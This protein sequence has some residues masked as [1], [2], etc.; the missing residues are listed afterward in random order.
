MLPPA[1]AADPEGLALGFD[2]PRTGSEQR[3]D[4][5]L[6]EA[7]ASPRHAHAHAIARRRERDEHDASVRRAAHAVTARR[8]GVD[9]QLEELPHGSGIPAE[10]TIQGRVSQVRSSTPVVGGY[11]DTPPL[12]P[13]R[14]GR[15]EA[16]RSSVLNR[17]P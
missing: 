6:H 8:Q 3:L 11:P 16:V 5:R 17:R 10:A 7:G 4:P 12:P 13:P 1:A 15:S 2:A 9:G 14:S